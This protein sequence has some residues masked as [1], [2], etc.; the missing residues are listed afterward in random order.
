MKTGSNH[1]Y[2]APAGKCVTVASIRQWQGWVIIKHIE[3]QVRAV[4]DLEL[5]VLA[6]ALDVTPADL[7][8]DRA[9]G[10]KL[11]RALLALAD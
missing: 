7:L 11:A 10:E 6:T 4:R 5:I 9:K 3:V 2:H 8:P 1:E